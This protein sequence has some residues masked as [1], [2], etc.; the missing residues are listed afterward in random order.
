M[1]TLN[2]FPSVQ[3]LNASLFRCGVT[4]LM[5]T[6]LA[7]L[8]SAQQAPEPITVGHAKITGLPEDWTHHHVVF[9]DPGTEAEAIRNGTYLE[10]L[11]ITSDPRY[12]V[13]QLRRRLPAQ[14]PAAREVA[15]IEEE[16]RAEAA[17]QTQEVIT[18]ARDAEGVHPRKPASQP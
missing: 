15:R 2:S 18:E 16:A 11:R 14:G 4:L 3:R 12:I 5:V 7:V 8:M 10:W 17:A 9:S 1:L 13:Q 6:G